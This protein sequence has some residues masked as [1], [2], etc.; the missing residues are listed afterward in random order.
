MPHWNS[1]ETGLS[2]TWGRGNLIAAVRSSV[3]APVSSGPMPPGTMGRTAASRAG[4][5]RARPDRERGCARLR[6]CVASTTAPPGIGGWNDV[7]V[8]TVENPTVDEGPWEALP[9]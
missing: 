6:T 1:R 3:Q 8:G 2:G 4:S 7:Y 5:A 9:L